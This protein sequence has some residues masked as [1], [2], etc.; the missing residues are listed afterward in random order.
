MRFRLP[1]LS[2]YFIGGERKNKTFLCVF[3][4]CIEVRKFRRLSSQVIDIATRKYIT[5]GKSIITDP[6]QIVIPGIEK[7]VYITKIF[8]IITIN[9]SILFL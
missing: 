2:P 3:V 4:L 7:V 8:R 6:V 9:L 1:S 5:T